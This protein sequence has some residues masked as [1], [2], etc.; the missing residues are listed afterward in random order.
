M[1]RIGEVSIRLCDHHNPGFGY[2]VRI[3]DEYGRKL[4]DTSHDPATGVEL[5]E[6]RQALRVVTYY[7]AAGQVQP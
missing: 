4:L 7:A 6:F 1:I 3:L 2:A 5:F